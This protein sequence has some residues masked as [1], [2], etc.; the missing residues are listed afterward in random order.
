MRRQDQTTFPFVF[1]SGQANKVQQTTEQTNTQ[2]ECLEVRTETAAYFD[3][4]CLNSD[5]ISTIY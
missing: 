4:I 5:F 2:I 1:V 3:Y